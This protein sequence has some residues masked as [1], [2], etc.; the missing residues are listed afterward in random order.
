VVFFVGQRGDNCFVGFF[1]NKTIAHRTPPQP[2]MIGAL[3]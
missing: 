1:F 2:K 3:H